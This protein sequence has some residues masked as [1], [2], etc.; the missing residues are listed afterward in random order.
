MV[1]VSQGDGAADE[2]PLRD[3]ERLVF[4][5]LEDQGPMRR[6]ELQ[7]RFSF[8]QATLLRILKRLEERGFVKAEATP[9]VACIVR[10]N[11]DHRNESLL[12]QVER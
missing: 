5:V 6:S 4:A 7:E 8:S 11:A 12:S 3:Q 2:G 10:L 1:S 9:A